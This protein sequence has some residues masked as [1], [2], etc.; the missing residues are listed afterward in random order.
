MR[1]SVRTALHDQGNEP[2]DARPEASP[3]PEPLRSSSSGFHR[4][5]RPPTGLRLLELIQVC[6]D[7]PHRPPTTACRSAAVSAPSTAAR[8]V[9]ARGT[10]SVVISTPDGVS[11]RRERR[12]SPGSGERRTSRRRTN[13]LTTRQAVGSSIRRRVASSRSDMPSFL[14]ITTIVQNCCGEM[15][16]PCSTRLVTCLIRFRTVTTSNPIGSAPAINA[17]LIIVIR[18]ILA[19][20]QM[21]GYT[22]RDGDDPE[23]VT[24]R[25]RRR[26]GRGG[27][28]AN[29]GI[30]AADIGRRLPSAER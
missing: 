25:G 2:N 15:P 13:V 6:N 22:A 10:R 23:P 27:A 9:S 5:R 1:L 29:S 14:A 30:R 20:K 11:M 4:G 16:W 24:R 21:P 7:L 26:R 8:I 28:G 12:R 3:G 18:I 17:S 19:V